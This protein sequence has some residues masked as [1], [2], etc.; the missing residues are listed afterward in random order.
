MICH[1]GTRTSGR[2][3]GMWSHGRD[4]GELL[5][6][7]MAI[8]LE[9]ALQNNQQTFSTS[10]TQAL[11]ALDKTEMQLFETLVQTMNTYNSP[12]PS[13]HLQIRVAGGWVR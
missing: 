6:T 2:Q 5:R 9:D 3:D 13:A 4:C 12:N 10:A 8:S 11:L 7:G 1:L